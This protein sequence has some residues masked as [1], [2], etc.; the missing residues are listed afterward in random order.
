[1]I[2]AAAITALTCGGAGAVAF[3][4]GFSIAV[5]GL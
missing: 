4:L 5:S 2:A 3:L 1:M